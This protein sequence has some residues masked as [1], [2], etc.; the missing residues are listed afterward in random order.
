MP[1]YQKLD[2]TLLPNAH[3]DDSEGG[4]PGYF[5]D[6]HQSLG[7][8]QDPDTRDDRLSDYQD[9]YYSVNNNS[10]N[11]EVVTIGSN[12]V[13]VPEEQ[14][15]E[16]PLLGDCGDSARNQVNE[17]TKGLLACTHKYLRTNCAAH[18]RARKRNLICSVSAAII[19]Q[20]SEPTRRANLHRRPSIKL[21]SQLLCVAYLW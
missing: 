16:V 7:I 15:W 4:F 20:G 8:Q 2:N 18:C 9:R 1:K 3:D 11:R 10:V 17:T 6:N 5:D 12:V 13:R 21:C 14:T 19:N